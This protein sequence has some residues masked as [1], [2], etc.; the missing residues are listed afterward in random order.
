VLVDGEVVVDGK[1]VVVVD[2]DPVVVVA[3]CAGVVAD[4]G[5]SFGME[6][7]GAHPKFDRT[8]WPTV[9]LPSS[10][11]V[12]ALTSRTCPWSSTPMRSVV[13]V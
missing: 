7:F 8:E 13:P 12:V 10:K 6:T 1:P 3:H 5:V 2:G 4:G 9:L 11:L